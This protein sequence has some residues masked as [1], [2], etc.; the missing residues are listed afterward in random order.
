MP[1][2]HPD[3]VVSLAH[4]LPGST[5]IVVSIA[6]GH[7]L[8]R[9]LAALGIIAGT[10]VAVIASNRSGP[11]IVQVRGGRVALGRGE[12]WKITVRPVAEEGEKARQ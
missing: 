4:L 6:G 2:A 10:P 11:I 1:A 7:L 9:R 3:K 5:C 8:V 12:A